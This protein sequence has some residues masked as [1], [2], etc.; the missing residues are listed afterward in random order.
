MLML[1]AG[2]ARSAPAAEKSDANRL[3]MTARYRVEAASNGGKRRDVREKTLRWDPT[4]TAIII[5]D[6][7]ARHWC[8]S[9]T[10]RVGEMAP[11]MDRVVA[12]ARAKGVFVIHAP[13]ACMKAYK[14][15]VQ[16]K[17]AQQAPVAD[18]MPKEI[19][20]WCHKLEGE[21]GMPVD[22]SNGG[23][24]D[25]P[26]QCPSG[27]PWRTQIDALRIA[28]QDAV[29]DQGPEVW[30][31]LE[32][33]GIE[34][35]LV[36]GVHTNMCVLGRPF[37]L[38]QMAKNGKNVALVRDLTDAMY[39]PKR[40]PNVAHRRG[41]ELVVE[42]VEKYVCP[43]VVADDITG[44]AGGPHLVFMIGE[45]EYD[46]KTTL[47]AYAKAELAPRGVRCTFVHVDPND[48][49]NF[50]GLEVLADADLLVLSVRRRGPVKDQL[51]LVRRHVGSGKP[52]VALR[53]ASHAFEPRKPIDDKHDQWPAFDKEV[54]G[55]DYQGH[56]NNKP[57]KGPDGFVK[58]V[59]E[60]K[61]HPIVAGLPTG[62]L[63]VVSHLYKNHDLSKTAVPL[64]IGRLEGRDVRE[65]V[66]WTNVYRG[67]RVFCTSLGA[68]EDFEMAAFRRLLLNGIYWACERAV[69]DALRAAD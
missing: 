54:L 50:P 51:A 60:A 62:E 40:P 17:R 12:D 49:N 29:S 5:C 57:P 7:W 14:D 36:M 24:C 10:R 16:R 53:T 67:G 13:S 63:R 3:T 48:E 18:N 19:E 15:T 1:G 69:P 23:G 2:M 55:A 37:G 6:M 34:N 61:G 47:P 28:E 68:P 43:T 4:K 39:S 66:A 26:T 32:D 56:Y 22:A 58:V 42:H 20:K 44:R 30:N 46:T 52:L 11:K 8:K 21:P 38:R 27:E 25:C 65:P 9:A 64:I 33:R 35:V 31:L 45:R 59:P 41:T